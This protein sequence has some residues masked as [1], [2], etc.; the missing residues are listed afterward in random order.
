MGWGH[1][2][3]PIRVICM[4]VFHFSGLTCTFKKKKQPIGE[5]NKQKSCF[6]AVFLALNIVARPTFNHFKPGD[7][8]ELPTA[9]EYHIFCNWFYFY[10]FYFFH[11]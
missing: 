10:F 6:I 9:V 5:K 11:I 3:E 1:W 4:K 8:L 7:N 2:G